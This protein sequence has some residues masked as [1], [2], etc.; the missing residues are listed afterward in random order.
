MVLRQLNPPSQVEGS[1]HQGGIINQFIGGNAHCIGEGSYCDAENRVNGE[2]YIQA[3]YYE[4]TSPV[5]SLM[6]PG[7]GCRVVSGELSISSSPVC[8][9]SP[10]SLVPRADSGGWILGFLSV[11]KDGPCV[12]EAVIVTFR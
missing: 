9:S 4:A 6:G 5:P 11:A 12:V 8:G 3:C 7:D 2:K 1:L 10:V